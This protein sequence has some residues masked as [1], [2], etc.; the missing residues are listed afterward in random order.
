[1]ANSD[2][3]AALPTWPDVGSH[4]GPSNAP[5]GQTAR[6]KS[7]SKAYRPPGALTRASRIAI[8]KTM[9]V[10]RHASR[11]RLAA[12]GWWAIRA[13]VGKEALARRQ[14]AI[15]NAALQLAHED[16]AATWPP[17]R[18]VKSSPGLAVA[19]VGP[20]GKGPGLVVKL[21]EEKRAVA[22]LRRDGAVRAT[23]AA[24]PRLGE[25]RH[26]L[27]EVLACELDAP[28][29][30]SVER[31]LGTADGRISLSGPEQIARP[32]TRAALS[33]ITEL[34]Q[35]TG[36]REVVGDPMLREWVFEPLAVVRS[37]YRPGRWQ[38][39][40]LAH[41][42]DLLASRLQGTEV[43]ISW[44]HG[45]YSPG[46]LLYGPSGRELVGIVDW[47]GATDLGTACL[48]T[49]LL[50]VTTVMLRANLDMGS[51]ISKFMAAAGDPSTDS[52]GRVEP[53]GPSGPEE[54]AKTGWAAT[55]RTIFGRDGTGSVCRG[56]KNHSSLDVGAGE[57]SNVDALWLCW[58]RHI[59]RN[60]LKSEGY[61]K[62]VGWR[63]TNIDL[64]LAQIERR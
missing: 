35:R 45:D 59:A 5:P 33:A 40:A 8:A 16:G 30:V 46:N 54:A 42:G 38:D 19:A 60:L 48:D 64:L 50:V 9:L 55:E 39:D 21:A 26:L 58:L 52:H 51:V 6:R 61:T 27:P 28:P 44:A 37:L 3:L 2:L 20:H 47:G 10:A 22:E 18:L 53:S 15:E 25:W 23:L 11:H 13:V 56:S 32:A 29:A 34:H 49:T 31:H 12:P 24:D 57:L 62:L 36:H 63:I 43:L 14:S 1:M 41:L 17:P 7:S 4:S